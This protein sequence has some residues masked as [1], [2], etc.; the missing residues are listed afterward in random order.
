MRF[1]MLALCFASLT[2]SMA[3]NCGPPAITTDGGDNPD[4]GMA[5]LNPDS[6]NAATCP[7]VQL[8]SAVPQLYDGG[9]AG[10]PNWVTSARLEWSDAPDDSLR[11]V[12][13]VTGS[14]GFR[15]I[16][17]SNPDLGLSVRNL[18]GTLHAVQGCPPSGEVFSNDGVY[19]SSTWIPLDAGTEVLIWVSAPHWAAEKT[20]SYQL[21]ITL[22]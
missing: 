22:E 13:P 2:A 12:T 9:T 4:S 6:G 19:D 18:D 8:P 3:C 20:G 21:R 11:Y 14:Y 5:S 17:S 7:H 10:Q 16:N 15:L 1:F